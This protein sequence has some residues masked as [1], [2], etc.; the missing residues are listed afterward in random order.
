MKLIYKKGFNGNIEDLPCGKHIPNAVKFKEFSSV[1]TMSLFVNGIAIILFFLLYFLTKAIASES[2]L[3]N[4]G[5]IIA[6]LLSFPHELI[7]AICF[8]ETVYLYTYLRKGMLFVTGQEHMSKTRFI[9]MSA[10]PTIFFGI[11]PFI[12]FLINPSLKTIGTI[13][14]LSISMGAGDFVNIFNAITQMPKGA[15]TYLYK[16]NSYWY[17]PE[18]KN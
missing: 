11:I 9:I 1:K 18:E 17:I 6:V 10:L 3:T 8:K 4:A 7:H 14:I 12:L 5:I 2:I 13:G 15:K 16:L